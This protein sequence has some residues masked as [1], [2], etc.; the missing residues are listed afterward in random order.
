MDASG[1]AKLAKWADRYF[2]GSTRK[3]TNVM[4]FVLLLASLRTLLP[5]YYC[6]LI[7]FYD[8]IA[9]Q[10][11]A[12]CNELPIW[13]RN[14]V[15]CDQ[16]LYSLI[17]CLYLTL[18]MRSPW[19]NAN[20]LLIYLYVHRNLSPLWLALRPYWLALRP[21]WLALRPLQLALRPFQLALRPFQ[22]ASR[23]RGPPPRLQP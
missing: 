12:A 11:S 4:I 19:S 2:S 6:C 9:T 21:C 1:F 23:V 13:P 5:F 15:Y 8:A 16:I 22:P 18:A 10:H 7:C 17:Y 20:F 3:I 14:L